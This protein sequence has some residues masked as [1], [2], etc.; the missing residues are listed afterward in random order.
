MNSALI[1]SDCFCW[2]GCCCYTNGAKRP[3]SERSVSG[4]GR[5]WFVVSDW[6]VKIIVNCTSTSFR[7]TIPEQKTQQIYG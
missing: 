3:T 2:L 4:F 1:E 5:S 7:L 6:C